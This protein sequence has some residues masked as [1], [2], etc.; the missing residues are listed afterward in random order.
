MKWSK[1]GDVWG[2]GRQHE[3]RLQ[4]IKV[5]NAYQFTRLPNQYVQKEKTQ[6]GLRLKR[7]LSGE[8]ILDLE[9]IGIRKNI[10]VTRAFEKMY[11]DY[12]DL[13]ERVSTYCAK[14]AFKLRRQD[15]CCKLIYVFLHTNPHRQ[16]LKQ[17]RSNIA[18][19]TYFPTNSTIDITK[20]ALTGLEKIYRE[21]YQYK[22]AGIILMA[23]TPASQRQLSLFNPQ[24][25]KHGALMKTIDKLNLANQDKVKFAGQDLAR[26][27][28]VKQERL[29]KRYTSRLDELIEI[30]C[31]KF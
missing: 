21:G 29:S 23:L 1:I 11:S 20:H 10:A 16:D 6:V 15:S 14:A 3:K 26:V 22:K 12:A 18:V 30:N 28:K 4:E 7:D 13:K 17:Y 8:C 2:I 5:Y 19:H 31:E 25:P 9:E 24:N 27:W